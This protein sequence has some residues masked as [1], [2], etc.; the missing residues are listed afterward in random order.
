MSYYVIYELICYISR[1]PFTDTLL[2]ISDA[3]ISFIENSCNV[4]CFDYITV[5]R[6][7]TQHTKHTLICSKEDNYGRLVSNFDLKGT[8]PSVY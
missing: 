7:K 6:Y 5:K 8:H 1:L 2:R 4:V 3:D